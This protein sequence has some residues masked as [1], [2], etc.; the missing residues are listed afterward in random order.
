MKKIYDL[1][2]MK[3]ASFVQKALLVKSELLAS[4]REQM[5]NSGF[6]NGVFAFLF[7]C[8]SQA[9]AQVLFS[10]DFETTTGDNA[11]GPAATQWTV[12]PVSYTH[13]TLPTKA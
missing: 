13:L 1:W 2:G 7:F 12:N 11:F 5:K 3:R 8:L 9:Q 10:A 4:S 6:C